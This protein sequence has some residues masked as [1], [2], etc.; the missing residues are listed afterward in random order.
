MFTKK[1]WASYTKTTENHTL[2]ALSE[3]K[4]NI[5]QPMRITLEILLCNV[6]YYRSFIYKI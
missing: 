5:T 6:Y 3:K 4:Q 1:N 2:P